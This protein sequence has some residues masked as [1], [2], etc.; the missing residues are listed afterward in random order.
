MIVVAS[1]VTEKSLSSVFVEIDEKR[2][3][4]AGD[5]IHIRRFSFVSR[6]LSAKLSFFSSCE[7]NDSNNK[8]NQKPIDFHFQLFFDILKV[9]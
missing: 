9:Y 1:S 5:E 8:S 2:M 7:S 4:D 3:M 6:Y